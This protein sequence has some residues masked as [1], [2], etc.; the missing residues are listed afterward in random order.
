MLCPKVP[1]IFVIMTTQTPLIQMS[2]DDRLTLFTS[3]YPSQRRTYGVEAERAWAKAIK[4]AT[5]EEMIQAVEAEK[6]SDQWQ[7]GIIP[8]MN[9][10]LNRQSWRNFSTAAPTTNLKQSLSPVEKQIHGGEYLRILDAMKSISHSYA[11]HQTWTK[12]DVTEYRLLQ[13]RRNELRKALGILR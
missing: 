11:E 4:L 13:A 10:W 2:K 5:V 1:V 9:T 12:E 7:R 8:L 6:Q 3:H